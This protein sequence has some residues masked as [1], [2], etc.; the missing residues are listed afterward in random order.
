MPQRV[1]EPRGPICY[2]WESIDW[3]HLV[4]VTRPAVSSRAQWWHHAHCHTSFC[5]TS[6]HP[7]SFNILSPH[8]S[9]VFPEPWRVMERLCLSLSTAASII[10]SAWQVM[11]LCINTAHCNKKLLWWRLR[12]ALIYGYNHDYLEGSLATCPFIKTIAAGSPV[13]PMTSP[14]TVP[15]PVHNTK[16]SSFLKR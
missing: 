8:S 15:A 9:A 3:P 13:G 14:A 7:L 4:Q 16:N 5:C 2:P 6:P 12:A 10:L 1:V 11:S